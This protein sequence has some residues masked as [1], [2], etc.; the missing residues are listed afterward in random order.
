M[1]IGY[2]QILA[3][4]HK[5]SKFWYPQR[6]NP[7]LNQSLVDTKGLLHF[8]AIVR[9]TIDQYITISGSR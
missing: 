4:L 6:S 3:I 7:G 2:M 8:E 5:G 9:V 1:C